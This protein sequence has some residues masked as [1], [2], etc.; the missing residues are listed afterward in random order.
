MGKLALQF[1]KHKTSLKPSTVTRK[2][3]RKL[4]SGGKEK[5]PLYSMALDGQKTNVMI[6]TNNIHQ[7]IS[8][9]AEDR[10]HSRKVLVTEGS[11]KVFT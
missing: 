1:A 4:L 6:S 11:A 7:N 3:E 5:N 8:I 9:F 10:P 2:P